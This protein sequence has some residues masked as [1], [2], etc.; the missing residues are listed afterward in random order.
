MTKALGLTQILFF[1]DNCGDTG[2]GMGVN[3]L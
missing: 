3:H 1:D 2:A